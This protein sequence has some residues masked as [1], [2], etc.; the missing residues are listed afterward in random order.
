MKFSL[1]DPSNGY[2]VHSY[3]DDSVT[4]GGQYFDHSLVVLPD[5]ILDDW[6]PQTFLELEAADFETLAALTP[7]LV[8]L[9]TGLS[10]HFPAPSLYRSLASA[11]IGL[12]IMTMPAAC[13]TYNVLVSEGRRA[14]AALLFR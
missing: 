5:R 13:R 6:R 11:G 7:D 8:I 12:E 1:A 10:L 14:A 2:V 9:G 4:I 3:A